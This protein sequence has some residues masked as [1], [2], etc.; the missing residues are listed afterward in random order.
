MAGNKEKFFSAFERRF[1]KAKGAS[2]LIKLRHSAIE[3]FSELGF[4]TTRHED[5]KYT[6][7]DP[8]TGLDFSLPEPSGVEVAA[9]DLLSLTFAA[10]AENRLVFIDGLYSGKHSATKNLPP[11]MCVQSLAELLSQDNGLLAPWLARYAGFHD[12]SF[13]AL[14]TAFMEDG[15]VVF[16]PSGCRLEEPVHIVFVSTGGEA[17]PLVFHPRNLIVC[18]E[19]SEIKIVESY[20]GIGRGVYF[21]NPVTEIAGGAGSVIDHYRLQ[22]ESDAAFHVGTISARLER[23]T[24][25]TSHHVTLG[26]ALVRNDVH[27]ILGGEG[28]ECNLNGLYLTEGDQHIDNH[29]EIDHAQP[30]A[31][32]REL[33]KGILR[34]RARGV[35]NGK[36]IVRKAAQKTDARQ[37]NKNLLLSKHAVVN[38]KPQLEIYAD[39]VKCSHG[40]TIG[41]LDRDALFYLRARGIGA[42]EARTLLSYGFAAE[43]LGRMK[44]AT[45]RAR[46]EEYLLMQFG[47]TA[48]LQ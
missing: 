17:Q 7:V 24:N 25:L 31:S 14:N 29:T 30:R 26:G 41:Q 22:R 44:I 37:T 42:D 2:W 10:G 13:V 11:G 20:T 47:R 23:A 19:G 4:P 15:G 21:A 33:Y 35:F 5:W 38:S 3:R 36:I 1:A 40:S 46:L 18:G 12:R 43:I 9:N 8:I 28:S 27:A 34:G 48:A 32:S 39:D 6:N 16:V 45:L